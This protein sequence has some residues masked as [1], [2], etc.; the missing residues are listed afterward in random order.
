MK[1]KY[2]YA[3]LLTIATNISFAGGPTS[4]GNYDCGEWF[5]RPQAKAWLLGYLSGLDAALTT[6]TTAS[7]LEKL[8]SA[9]QAYLWMDNY[10]KTNPLKMINSGAISLY[11]ELKSK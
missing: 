2:L 5:T 9:G 8:N 11:L 10:C 3:T 7:T 4:F 6:E 1:T